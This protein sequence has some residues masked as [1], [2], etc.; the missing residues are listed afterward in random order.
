MSRYE[1][2]E[3]PD[4]RQMEVLVAGG[5]ERAL[6]SFTGTPG[7]AVP[8]E[9]L[10]TVAAFHRLLLLQPLR[11][12]YG[13]STPQPG[14]RI[15]DFAAD[16]EAVLN[17]YGIEDAICMGGSGG[18]PHAVA[19]AARLPQC[20]AAAP[21]VSPAPRGA[22]GL[23]FYDGMALSNQEEWR[24]ADQGEA[25][26]RPWL[27]V[28]AGKLRPGGD[29]TFVELF[30]DTLSDEDRG[31]FEAGLGEAIMARFKKAIEVGIEGWLQDDIAMTTPWG[32]ELADIQTPVSFWAGRTDQFVSYRHTVWMAEQIPTSD[33]HLYGAEGHIS[34]K[35]NH[36][37]EMVQDLV[38]RAGWSE[39]QP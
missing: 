19:M 31:A 5:G 36:L 26:V 39:K 16:V 13:R 37:A 12:G 18:G 11:P 6:V 21:Y 4:E 24:L 9:D 28:A 20:R 10:T 14:R 3:L 32:F 34:L 33:L 25:A 30:P 2:V 35:V 7:G 8:D 38:T 29:D 27:E 23:D 15:V 1:M 17:H 22:A